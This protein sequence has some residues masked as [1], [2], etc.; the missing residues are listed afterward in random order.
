MKEENVDRLSFMVL[1]AIC[2]LITIS[3]IPAE[4]KYGMTD[5]PF[6]A[7]GICGVIVVVT[8]IILLLRKRASKNQIPV[9]CIAGFLFIWSLISY[10]DSY[11]LHTALWGQ[12]G[13]YDGLMT[14]II[15]VFIFLTSAML[16]NKKT[17]RLF[18]LIICVGVFQCLWAFYQVLPFGTSYYKNLEVIAV[19]DVNLTSGLTGS[20]FFFAMLM[21]AML[22]IALYGA[23]FGENKKRRILYTIAIIPFTYAILQ[24]HTL[25]GII[26]IILTSLINIIVSIRC[27]KIK[28]LTIFLYIVM[29]IAVFISLVEK[30]KFYDGGIVWQDSFYRLGVTG[31]F[32]FNAADFDV[33]NLKELYSYLWN[34]AISVIKQFPLTGTGIDCFA[35]TQYKTTSILQYELNS[36]DRPYNDYL[37]LT[38]TRGIPY[39]IGYAALIVYSVANG[40]KNA[41]QNSEWYFK[42]IPAVVIL[43]AVM[44]IFNNSSISYM[45]FIWIILGLSFQNV[46]KD[47]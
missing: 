45:P 21:N 38:A 44:S 41:R 1:A 25:S 26:G 13:R 19:K 34:Q 40:I 3:Q 32:S 2:I 15:Y 36:I 42:A 12:D 29:W 28:K 39:I 9:F 18:N 27:H 20:P 37:F 33:N 43:F 23:V 10:Y 6:L 4:F 11:N 17:E 30:Y 16:A 31:Y 47:I 24:T 35:Y 22:S 46:R 8:G 7:L 5:M 14:M